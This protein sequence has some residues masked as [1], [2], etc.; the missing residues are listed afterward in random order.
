MTNQYG[1]YFIGCLGYLFKNFYR[2]LT[3]TFLNWRSTK[4]IYINNVNKLKYA[5]ASSVFAVHGLPL[6]NLVYQDKK[7]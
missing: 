6:S 3:S 7:L 2:C 5:D 4:Y 1:K